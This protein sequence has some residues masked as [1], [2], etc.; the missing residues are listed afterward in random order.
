MPRRGGLR[1][2][3]F[4]LK[5]LTVVG[6]PMPLPI[7]VATQSTGTAAFDVGRDG[8][9]AYVPASAATVPARTLVWVDRQGHEEEI[10]ATRPR[11]YLSPALT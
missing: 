10:K 6:D 4:D 3:R 8:T 5:H 9:L 7:E 11:L 1:A 2:I